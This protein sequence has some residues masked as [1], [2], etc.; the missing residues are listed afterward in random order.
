LYFERGEMGRFPLGSNGREKYD[1]VYIGEVIPHYLNSDNSNLLNNNYVFLF[2]TML[3]QSEDSEWYGHVDIDLI[4]HDLLSNFNYELRKRG[5][6]HVLK[7]EPLI[8]N[9]FLEVVP[10]E[11]EHGIQITAH[12][13]KQNIL[14]KDYKVAMIRDFR[15]LL[16]REN[17]MSS[18]DNFPLLELGP[19]FQAEID[20]KK[21]NEHFYK[22]KN[23]LEVL[24]GLAY[25]NEKNSKIK[26]AIEVVESALAQDIQKAENERERA[27]KRYID[28]KRSLKYIQKSLPNI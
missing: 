7:K 27:F 26:D 11:T 18:Y 10:E 4:R 13:K 1:V 24:K 21:A 9:D 16:V 19:E 23:S 12:L 6:F 22:L 25:R 8:L 17:N 14:N 3:D 5:R 2:S 15:V 20:D 28:I